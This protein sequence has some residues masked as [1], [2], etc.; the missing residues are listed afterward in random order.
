MSISGDAGYPA[1]ACFDPS[2]PFNLPDAELCNVCDTELEK[3][4]FC[5]NEDNHHLEHPIYKAKFWMPELSEYL[6]WQESTDFY[7]GNL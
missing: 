2:A 7:A 1:S 4:M 6:T 5:P 3:G